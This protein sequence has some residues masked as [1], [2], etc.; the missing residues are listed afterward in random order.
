MDGQV[1]VILERV[2]SSRYG[3]P[4]ELKSHERMKSSVFVNSRAPP[5]R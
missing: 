5:D 2:V 1:R 3:V 4:L